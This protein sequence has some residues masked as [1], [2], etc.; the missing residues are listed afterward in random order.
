LPSW[1]LNRYSIK[2]FNQFYFSSQRRNHGKSQ[3]QHYQGYFYPLDS[4]SH[5]N[6]IYGGKGFYQYQFVVPLSKI[7][8]LE[9]ILE[10]IVESGMGS[11]LAVLKEFGQLSSPGM[12]SFPREGYCLALDF[13]N[14]GKRTERLIFELDKMVRQAGGAAYPAKDRLMSTESFH[15]YFPELDKFKIQIDPHFSSDFWR[16]VSAK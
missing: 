4:I 11:F 2:L 13:A 9:T 12:L 15:A 5:W 1:L 8:V 3:T 7:E 16:R 6:R 14:R 10:R